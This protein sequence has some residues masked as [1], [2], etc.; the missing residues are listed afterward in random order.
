M[1]KV[2]AITGW[3][4]MLTAFVALVELPIPIYGITEGEQKLQRLRKKIHIKEIHRQHMQLTEHVDP[5]MVQNQ[6]AGQFHLGEPS[7]A[8]VKCRSLLDGV[9]AGTGMVGQTE[10]VQ[11]LN[12]LTSGKVNETYFDDVDDMF[13]VV[14]YQAACAQDR[15]CDGGQGFIL[16]DDTLQSY[17]LISRFCNRILERVTT[18]TGLTFGYSI[19]FDTDTVS[20]AALPGCLETAT[21]NLLKENFG[22]EINVPMQNQ[23]R[24]LRVHGRASRGKSTV[25]Y[26]ESEEERMFAELL[27]RERE[28]HRFLSDRM[29]MDTSCDY[30]IDVSVSRIV[31]LECVPP[32]APNTN[33]NCGLVR[34]SIAVSAPQLLEPFE[35]GLRRNLTE[36]LRLAIDGDAFENYFPEDCIQGGNRK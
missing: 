33:T 17:E 5:E 4:L 24:E 36:A 29:S 35:A 6:S 27:L 31:P 23:R 25:K 30:E 32:A 21:T 15:P 14:F 22:C 11:F 9:S 1:F 18:T 13:T 19:R 2:A 20:E 8:Y 16:L 26:F 34:S 28:D 7:A 3:V 12:V 10:F